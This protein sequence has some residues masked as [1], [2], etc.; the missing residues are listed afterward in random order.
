MIFIGPDLSNPHAHFVTNIVASIGAD[1][2]LVIDLYEVE[3]KDDIFGRITKHLRDKYEQFVIYNAYE[4]EDFFIEFRR[5]FPKLKLVTVFSDDEWRHANYDRYLALYSHVSAVTDTGNYNR[6]RE[7]GIE[8]CYMPWACNPDAFYPLDEEEKLYDVSFIGAA[9]GERVDYVRFLL[10]MGVKV[11]VFGQGWNRFWR[12][13]KHWGGYLT[14]AQ[15]LR[16]ISQS[17]IN[18]NFLWTS[19]RPERSVIKGR[20]MELAA[21]RGFQLTSP[22]IDLEENGF[23][24][25]HNIAVFHDKQNLLDQI[26]YY[27]GHEKERVRIAS[28]AYNHVLQQHTWSK[29]FLG[30]FKRLDGACPASLSVCHKFRIMVVVR[31]GVCHQITL[32]DERL[33][34]RIVNPMSSWRDDARDMDGVIIL[35]HES[36]LNNES[37]YMMAFGLIADGS[38]M[39]AANFYVDSRGGRVWIR[40][41]DRL[42]ERKQTLLHRLPIECFMFSG[43]YAAE[44]GCKLRQYATDHR[45]SYIEYPSFRIKLPYYQ[46]R[47][48]RLYFAHHANPIVRFNQYL[49]ELRVG[50][51]FSLGMD[52]VWQ[53]ILR[54]RI[55]A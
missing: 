55:G 21:C 9:Y 4:D 30:I 38:D 20:L 49:R 6:Y 33:D 39:I 5:Q 8:A 29:R 25:G 23:R 19:A 37:L 10:S 12:M 35:N 18:L 1:D 17:K 45:V 7:Y 3:D 36:T 11:R 53:R 32:D 14:H 44:R 48:L 54:N 28:R 46:S 27:L 47:K 15:M 26:R 50:K 13:R 24:D 41:R 52:K 22:A 16:V 31:D 40:F 2:D 34:I 42:I 43:A 51:A